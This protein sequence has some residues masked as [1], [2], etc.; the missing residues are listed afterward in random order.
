M[1]QV[2]VDVAMEK[3]SQEILSLLKV[4][5]TMVTDTY[6]SSMPLH[7]GTNAMVD[8]YTEQLIMEGV[9]S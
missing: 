9:I 3:T 2:S 8:A 6:I 1:A 4:V 7:S 5:K